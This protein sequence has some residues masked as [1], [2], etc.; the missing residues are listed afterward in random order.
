MSEYII[1]LKIGSKEF[2]LRTQDLRGEEV[3]RNAAK[4]VNERLEARS[5]IAGAEAADVLRMTCFD[6][7]VEILRLQNEQ[8]LIEKDVQTLLDKIARMA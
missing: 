5:H 3:L 1:N 6:M 8:S 2:A 4:L 7:A